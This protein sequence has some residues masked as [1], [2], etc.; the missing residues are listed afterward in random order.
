MARYIWDGAN[1]VIKSETKAASRSGGG[2]PPGS[3]WRTI[4]GARVLI[5]SDGTPVDPSMRARFAVA[6]SQIT[7]PPD[8]GEVY[9]N[10][11]RLAQAVPYDAWLQGTE[12]TLAA[13]Q[14]AM[15]K[16]DAAMAHGTAANADMLSYM[17]L[18]DLSGADRVRAWA[19][20]PAETRGF[21]GVDHALSDGGEVYVP[22][23]GSIEN[24]TAERLNAAIGPGPGGDTHYAPHMLN[25]WSESGTHG[26]RGLRLA[27]AA[28]EELGATASPYQRKRQMRMRE[29]FNADVTAQPIDRKLVRQM[30]ADT[31]ADLAKLPGDTVTLYRGLYVEHGPKGAPLSKSYQPGS[32]VKLDQIGASLTSWSANPKTAD[33]FGELVLKAVVPKARILS[34]G[35]TGVGLLSEYEVVV[36]GVKGDQA[37]V[38]DN[39]EWGASPPT[40]KSAPPLSGGRWVTLRNGQHVYLRPKAGREAITA[41]ASTAPKAAWGDDPEMLARGSMDHAVYHDTVNGLWDGNPAETEAVYRYILHQDEGQN[42]DKPSLTET[43]RRWAGDALSFALYEAP[44]EADMAGPAH[45]AG[46]SVDQAEHLRYAWNTGV[47]GT[48]GLDGAWIAVQKAAVDEFGGSLNP[49]L[50]D[51]WDDLVAGR[52]ADIRRARETAAILKAEG[53]WES[54]SS[55]SR[56]FE[57]NVSASHRTAFDDPIRDVTKMDPDKA[58]PDVSGERRLLRAMYNKTQKD[59]ASIPGDTVT[60]Y[61]GVN[62]NRLTAS[63]ERQRALQGKP[64]RDHRLLA[65]LSSWSLDPSVARG[66]GTATLVARIPKTRIVSTWRTGFGTA[67]EGEVVVLGGNPADQALVLL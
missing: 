11:H 60:V 8:D 52:A 3:Y 23:P 1:W 15:A 27:D 45:E 14:A 35:R 53:S 4:R 62:A 40:T 18:G 47:Q 31:Q 22:A 33:S 32:V 24:Q 57:A 67:K 50:S 7:A 61:R 2:V 51:R 13:V 19:A 59:L 29:M 54:Y 5:G 39:R 26:E 38:W 37:R 6:R 10:D 21:E 49:E 44:D 9:G 42:L 63:P 64:V 43:R 41:G 12:V 65:P 46:V 16:D 17:A 58:E 30:Y 34:T 25:A 66:F 28:V 36:I 48:S 55:A 56:S 20:Q